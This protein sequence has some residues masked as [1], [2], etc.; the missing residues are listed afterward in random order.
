MSCGRLLPDLSQLMPLHQ[1]EAVA[2]LGFVGL[3]GSSFSLLEGKRR[4]IRIYSVEAALFL[5]QAVNKESPNEWFFD[6]V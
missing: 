3:S 2:S 6:I 1:A 4:W 5:F